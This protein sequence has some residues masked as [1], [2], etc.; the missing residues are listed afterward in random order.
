MTEHIIGRR[1][2][3]RGAG[4]A[5]VGA[6]VGGLGVA[7]PAMADEGNSARI[8]G[9]WFITRHDT[10]A[11]GTVKAILSLTA[12]GVIIAHDINPAGAPLTGTWSGSGHSFEAT[13][14]TGEAGE[15]PNAPGGPTVRVRIRDGRVSGDTISGKYTVAVFDPTT[16]HQIA[17]ATGSFTGT[18][19]EA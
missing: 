9:S 10:S 11:P 14:W 1:S 3:L 6:A 16:N 19:V 5:A 12:G 18:F 2:V 13:M 4:V 8:T 7:S 17:S 15:G